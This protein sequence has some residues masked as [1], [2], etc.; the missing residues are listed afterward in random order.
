MNEPREIRLVR[1]AVTSLLKKMSQAAVDLEE[2]KEF[3]IN[4]EKYACTWSW[5]QK[6]IQAA[7]RAVL[8]RG[9]EAFEA[10]YRFRPIRLPSHDELIRDHMAIMAGNIG[11]LVQLDIYENTTK[12]R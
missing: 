9:R 4:S 11:N 7:R 1:N 12:E 2:L 10:G 8:K 3:G 6:S 5:W